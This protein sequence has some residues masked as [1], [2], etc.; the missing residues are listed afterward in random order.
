MPSRC[1]VQAPHCAMPQPNFVPVI[2]KRSRSTQSSGMSAGASTVLLSPL[3]VSAT[4]G[5]PYILAFHSSL[6]SGSCIVPRSG[7]VPFSR[8]RDC[9]SADAWPIRL[10]ECRNTLSAPERNA[11]TVLAMRFN[12]SEAAVAS[13]ASGRMWRASEACSPKPK[14]QSID[15]VVGPIAAVEH[16]K[17]LRQ[18]AIANLEPR[19]LTKT[20]A[21]L[22]PQRADAGP[23]RHLHGAETLRSKHAGNFAERQS[24]VPIGK[25]LQGAVGKCAIERAVG[26]RQATGIAADVIDVDTLFRGKALGRHQRAE[27]RIETHGAKAGARRGDGPAAPRAADIEQ[28]TRRR[29]ARKI[30]ESGL[31]RRAPGRDSRNRWTAARGAGSP[32]RRHRCRPRSRGGFALSIPREG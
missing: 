10:A 11:G 12:C 9:L 5:P 31:H 24:A 17:H 25:V 13:R 20:A 14:K 15:T 19:R 28:S 16:R 1:T 21:G 3:I 22:V 4:M 30:A 8:L 18:R 26:K 2:P 32:P 27:H 29:R 6:Y 7:R 23:V